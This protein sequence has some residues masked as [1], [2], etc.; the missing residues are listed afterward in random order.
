LPLGDVIVTIAETGQ[1]VR[2]QK[3]GNYVFPEVA[4]G[5]YTLV[6]T[7]DG[8][9]RQVKTNVTVGP[10][11]LTDLDIK[12]ASEFT[13]VEEV[14]VQD[15]PIATR[16]IPIVIAPTPGSEAALLNIREEAP[17]Q[18]DL[19]GS[20][21]IKQAGASTAADALKFVAGTSVQDGKYAVVRG[22]PDRYVSSQMN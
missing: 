20:T 6:F 19:I 18:L 8:F 16:P 13:D 5:T 9:V 1:R 22:L 11:S 7:K 15:I 2:S 3:E 17:G 21:V 14:T 12:L 10:G 4:P